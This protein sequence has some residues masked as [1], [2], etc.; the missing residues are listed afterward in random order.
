MVETLGNYF[1]RE[2]IKVD[3]MDLSIT[4][5]VTDAP[6]QALSALHPIPATVPHSGWS[7]GWREREVSDYPSTAN[8]RITRQMTLS[9]CDV[10]RA[11]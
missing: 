3:N 1:V 9:C 7:G 2:R 11:V 8:A 4:S 6:I 5:L 10:I